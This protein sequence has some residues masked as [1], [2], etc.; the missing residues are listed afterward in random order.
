[1]DG[2][3]QGFEASGDKTPGDSIR[4]KKLTG[5]R[6]LSLQFNRPSTI[7]QS[8]SKQVPLPVA[9]DD[10]FLESGQPPER[11]AT[12]A[13][14]VSFLES[15]DIISRAQK[16]SALMED[17]ELEQK[18]QYQLLFGH[19]DPANFASVLEIDQALTNWYRQLPSHLQV[20]S[21]AP[22][23]ISAITARQAYMTRS[24]YLHCRILIFRPVLSRFC[25]A[26]NELAS[27]I[28]KFDDS[29]PQR[30]ALSCSILCLRAAHEMIEVLYNTM[31]N[32]ATWGHIPNWWNAILYVYNSATVLQA[33]RLPPGVETSV[34]D[35]NT[36]TSWKHA[37][38]ILKRLQKLG[39]TAQRSLVALEILADK[40]TEAIAPRGRNEPGGPSPAGGLATPAASTGTNPSTGPTPAPPAAP[41]DTGDV[42]DSSIPFPGPGDSVDLA[43]FDFDLNDMSWLTS[44]PADL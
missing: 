27:S 37:I 25:L 24:R 31:D 4:G 35:Y 13:F 11:P 16:V 15:F 32:R 21:V 6:I 17:Q 1:M 41:P 12:L 2:L 39:S 7:D 29:L 9:V 30:M 10:E 43:E 20:S 18:D 19:S 5:G 36:E 28:T 8:S 40:I 14:Y 3:C 26:Q 38:E 33:A 23:D 42:E 44:A 22:S 34:G